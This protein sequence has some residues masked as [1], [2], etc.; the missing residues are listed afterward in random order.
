MELRIVTP[1]PHGSRR[2]NRVTAL[3][4][5]V[6]LRGEGH[7]VRVEDVASASD[8]PCDVLVALHAVRG[9]AALRRAS[10]ATPRPR[11]VV[12]LTGTDI[13]PRISGEALETLRLAD[14]IVALNNRVEAVLPADVRERVRVILPSAPPIAD[15]PKRTD[16]LVIVA[17][18][19]LRAVK[20]PL[21]AARAVRALPASS[22]LVIEHLGGSLDEALAREAAAES[23]SNPRWTWLGDQRRH[24]TL[25]AIAAAHALLLTSRDE[26]GPTVIA[27]ALMAGTPVLA[28]AIDGVL[29]LLDDDYP[30]TYPPGDER[31]LS[32]LLA[33]FELDGSFRA[34]L[35]QVCAERR[36]E[37]DSARE[38]AEVCALVRELR[39]DVT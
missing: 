16:A 11:L 2:G 10:A 28:P 17:A 31:A 29:G 8:E 1:A 39:F 6:F 15:V 33:R 3:R 27:E 14:R 35:V 20:D 37:F 26:G 30:G 19:H 18:G 24:A 5:A 7:A 25:H 12:V 38:R 4:W 22:R 13:Y 32:A 9:A 36:S 34:G 23:A 21:F